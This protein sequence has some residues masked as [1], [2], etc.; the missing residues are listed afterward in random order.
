[1]FVGKSYRS[2]LL[3]EDAKM[4]GWVHTKLSLG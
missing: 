4:F 2:L 3:V 1:M